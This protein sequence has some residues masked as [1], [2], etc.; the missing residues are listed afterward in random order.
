MCQWNVG[1]TSINTIP[2]IILI[3]IRF[4]LVRF[5]IEY[6]CQQTNSKQILAVLEVLK[7]SSTIRRPLDP[8]YDRV[9]EA[10]S[11]QPESCANLVVKVLSWL[12]KAKRTLTIQE[13]QTAVSVELELGS[14][15]LD[16][17]DP[18]DRSTLLD[19]CGGLVTIDENSGTIRLAH[20]TVQEYLLRKSIIPKDSNY[21]IVKTCITYLSSNIFSRACPSSVSLDA[22]FHLGPFLEYA[23]HY[24]RTHLKDCDENLSTDDILEF[25]TRPGNVSSWM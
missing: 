17:L 14:L 4:L 9:M 2:P 15:E 22:R 13:I 18:P 23:A 20:L 1:K 7:H 10:V 16:E 6:L 8:T 5:H 19:V 25:L 12:V 24:L 11:Q 21:T 3:G